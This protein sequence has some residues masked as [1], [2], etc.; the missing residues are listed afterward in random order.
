MYIAKIYLGNLKVEKA[1]S[2]NTK[3]LVQDVENF[4]ASRRWVIDEES[5]RMTR[6]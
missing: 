5:Y 2:D 6:Y 4:R 1:S 3:S